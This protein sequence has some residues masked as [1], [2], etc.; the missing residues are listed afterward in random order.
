MTAPIARFEDK[1]LIELTVA[2]Q[3][4]CFSVLMDRHGKAVRKCIG[5][6]VRNRSDVE[7]LIQNTFLKAWRGLPTFRFEANFR[8]WLTSVAAN[9]ALALHRRGRSRPFCLPITNLE[10]VR[11][12]GESPEQTLAR[13]E[14]RLTVRRA[15]AGLPNKYREI[16]TLCD[17]QQLTIHEA[18]RQLKS[19]TSLVKTRL[20]R[21]RHMLAKALKQDAAGLPAIVPKTDGSLAIAGKSFLK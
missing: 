21:A 6:L 11:S 14:A 17:L 15:I 8:T 3:S 7:D 2:G 9:E 16:L 13:L 5:A 18:A 1:T 4:E 19:S 10:N 12:W 20:F